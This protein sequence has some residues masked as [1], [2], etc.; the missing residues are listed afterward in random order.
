M[1]Q[2]KEAVSSEF[3]PGGLMATRGRT[4]FLKKQ[5]EMARKDRQLRKAEI[6]EQ[7]KLARSNS[8]EGSQDI[9]VPQ[10]SD[11]SSDEDQAASH[12]QVQS[13]NSPSD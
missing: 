13:W 10:D 2:W 9:E 11:D 4:S 12:G 3:Q 5:K 7:R 6:R 8:P 1:I